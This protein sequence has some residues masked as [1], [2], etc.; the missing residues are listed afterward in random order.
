MWK[1]I[2]LN[3]KYISE[4]NL[5]LIS[6]AMNSLEPIYINISHVSY[7]FGCLFFQNK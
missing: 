3:A 4:L 5:Y 2:S 1:I 7:C 6:K